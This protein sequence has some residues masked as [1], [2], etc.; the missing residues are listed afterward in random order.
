MIEI[1]S[2]H[3]ETDADT[4]WAIIEPVIEAGDTYTFAPGT[5]REQMVNW[6]FA[7]GRDCYAAEDESGEVLG[8]FWLRANQPGLGNHIGNAAY[9]VLPS[10]HG[11][12]IGRQMGE[13]SLDEA[14]RLG[15]PRCS[16]TSSFRQTPP[17]YFYN[18]ALEWK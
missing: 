15:L 13:Y 2:S 1:R 11:K 9:M 8:I 7:D 12:G 16:S 18:K 4:V 14:R 6:W 17:P 5:P 3:K 10:A